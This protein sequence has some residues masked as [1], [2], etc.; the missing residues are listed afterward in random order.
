MLTRLQHRTLSVI[1]QQIQHPC[2]PA[3][4]VSQG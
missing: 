3:E 1:H 2:R 4:T